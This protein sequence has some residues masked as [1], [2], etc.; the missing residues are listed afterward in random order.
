MKKMEFGWADGQTR[1][2]QSFDINVNHEIKELI[3]GLV[4]DKID[5]NNASLKLLFKS[6]TPAGSYQLKNKKNQFFIR[7]SS[8]IGNFNLENQFVN[9]LISRKVAVNE[10]IYGGINFNWKDIIYRLD[11]RPFLNGHCF[12][13][14]IDEFKNLIELINNLH[15][16][17]KDFPKSQ[18]IMENQK[19]VSQKQN[20][21][22]NQC[23]SALNNEEFHFFKDFEHWARNKEKWLKNIL[24]EYDPFIENMPNAQCLHGQI[25]PGN[26]LF[27]DR[28]PVLFDTET[29]I[30][31]Y[32]PIEWDISWVLQRF[33]IN[34]A[35]S[36]KESLKFIE[37]LADDGIKI[38]KLIN[39][40]KINTTYSVLAVFDYLINKKVSVPQS[41][42]DKFYN[43]YLSLCDYELYLRKI[44]E[45]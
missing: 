30:N 21:I 44:Y 41:E 31:T 37:L 36:K 14:N 45:I 19:F 23:L 26:V 34:Q 39:M 9:F 15:D 42:L 32:A 24:N 18:E 38:K 28:H 40:S 22:R 4:K 10:F 35:P 12:E 2:I 13:L 8:R 17:S 16:V 5:I 25:H 11:V 3:F 33:I 1:A 20:E 27:I 29:S 43:N 6:E 7:V